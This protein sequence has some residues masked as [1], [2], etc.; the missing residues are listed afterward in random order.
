MEETITFIL[1]AVVLVF[2]ILQIILFFKLWGMTNDVK[3]LTVR[4]DSP[5]MNY[6]I[7]EIHKKNPNIADL[8]FDSLYNAMQKHFRYESGT[9]YSASTYSSMKDKYKELYKKA[10]VEFPSVFENI[11]TNED[12]ES[13]F[14]L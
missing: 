13:T 8:L 9:A 14:M 6:I 4:F 5:D 7:K 12:W 1:A 2:G 11:N 10:G 3:R